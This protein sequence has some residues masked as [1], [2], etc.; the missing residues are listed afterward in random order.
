MLCYIITLNIL[1]GIYNGAKGKIVGFAFTY[2]PSCVSVGEM[3]LENENN[4]DLPVV[5]VQ[6]DNDIGYSV[7]ANLPNVVPF[8]EQFDSSE[9]YLREYRRWQ[10]PLV[11]AFATT[12]HKMQ[13]STVRGNCVTSPSIFS[14]WARGLD[15]V[16][17]SRVTELKNLYL[18]RPLRENHFHTHHKER[19]AIAKEYSR[20]ASKFNHN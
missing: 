4:R 18:L 17:N 11:A 3:S 7:S 2:D 10:I 14:P 9:M 5:L 12:T 16:A 1:L 19:A 20:L 8:T 13:G 15:Y 6:M